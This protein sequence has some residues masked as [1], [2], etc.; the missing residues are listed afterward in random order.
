MAYLI[1]LEEN[2]YVFYIQNLIYI[3]N[4][5]KKKRPLNERSFKIDL[6]QVFPCFHWNKS[7]PPTHLPNI[8]PKFKFVMSN[9]PLS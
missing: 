8:T 2:I 6:N 5:P 1:I 7:I 4:N 9:R 3:S